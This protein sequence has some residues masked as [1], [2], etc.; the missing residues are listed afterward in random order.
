MTA[1]ENKSFFKRYIST[2]EIAC[3][4]M[5]LINVAAFTVAG[6]MDNPPGMNLREPVQ[7]LTSV[8]SSGSILFGALSQSIY[9]NISS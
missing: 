5:A 6:L 4:F 3:F 8:L 1:A 7:H 9:D 2:A